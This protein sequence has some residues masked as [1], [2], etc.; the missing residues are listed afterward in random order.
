VSPSSSPAHTDG[1]EILTKESLFIKQILQESDCGI[2]EKEYRG[3]PFSQQLQNVKL[4]VPLE[5]VETPDELYYN[6][7]HKEFH[8]KIERS[9][10]EMKMMFNFLKEGNPFRGPAK[11][12]TSNLH[13]AV[14]IFNLNKKLKAG[15]ELPSAI[16]SKRSPKLDIKTLLC[17]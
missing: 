10:H 12:H 1:P 14:A 3:C 8:K 15:M 16:P 17:A 11:R 2:L 6:A 4:L 5:N 7:S 13:I 9:V